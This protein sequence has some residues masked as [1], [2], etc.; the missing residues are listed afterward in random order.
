MGTSFRLKKRNWEYSYPSFLAVQIRVAGLSSTTSA[1]VQ[2]VSS[3]SHFGPWN[4]SLNFTSYKKI[5]SPK[6][7][8]FSL[9]WVTPPKKLHGT[10]KITQLKRN[11]IFH[12]PPFFGS[13]R[14][15]F[16][17]WVSKNHIYFS[18]ED[19]SYP[20]QNFCRQS[21]LRWSR[22]TLNP[23][24]VISG[25]FSF[26]QND[27]PFKII[28][29]IQYFHIYIYIYVLYILYIHYI[30]YMNVVHINIH[31]YRNIWSI[32]YIRCFILYVGWRKPGNVNDIDILM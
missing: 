15:F 22:L 31:V 12:P 6:V 10:Q 8:S 14:E 11:I 29:L 1:Q 25:S 28:I 18:P 32:L 20:P 4:T 16:R 9:G 27:A 21:V 3:L 5:N 7:S 23:K 24:K 13:K 26:Q 30:S 19:K 2:A 17:V